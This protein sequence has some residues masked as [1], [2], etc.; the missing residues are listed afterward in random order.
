[1]RSRH[2]SNKR[3][4]LQDHTSRY[5]HSRAP[6]MSTGG[7]SWTVEHLLSQAND[8]SSWIRRMCYTTVPYP[9]HRILIWIQHRRRLSSAISTWEPHKLSTRLLRC[10]TATGNRI[11]LTTAALSTMVPAS[12]SPHWRDQYPSRAH[13][14]HRHRSARQYRKA[15]LG[16]L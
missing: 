1:M 5:S 15:L 14:R 13:Q 9:S 3:P 6:R 4:H 8:H 10:P 16:H 7:L 12:T 2:I 11:T